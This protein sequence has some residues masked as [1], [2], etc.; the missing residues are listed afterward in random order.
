MDMLYSDRILDIQAR[1]ESAIKRRARVGKAGLSHG[2]VLGV[3]IK[4]D[5]VSLGGSLKEVGQSARRSI[6]NDCLVA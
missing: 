1:I 6:Y 2:V 3:E 5:G 4:P